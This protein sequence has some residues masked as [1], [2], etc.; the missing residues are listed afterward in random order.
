M[1][2]QTITKRVE[3]PSKK[4]TKAWKVFVKD[5]EGKLK[6]AYLG[7]IHGEV[8]QGIWLKAKEQSLHSD[9]YLDKDGVKMNSY[10]NTEYLSGFHCYTD[11]KQT[12]ERHPES[13]G[14]IIVEVK[15][16]EI[17]THG[18]QWAFGLNDAV[19]ARQMFVPKQPKTK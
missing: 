16:K 11:E 2:L 1:C 9:F 15:V 3:K 12:R 19:V 8:I 14:W 17:T 10:V 13:T 7:H 6:Y 5:G 18:T 4:V